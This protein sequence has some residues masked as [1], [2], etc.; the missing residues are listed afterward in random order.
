M[1]MNYEPLKLA[2][3]AVKTNEASVRAGLSKGDFRQSDVATARGIID[4]YS[5]VAPDYSSY[6]ALDYGY[7]VALRLEED[8]IRAFDDTLKRYANAVANVRGDDTKVLGTHFDEQ[9]LEWAK[10]ISGSLTPPML[11]QQAL[12][13][14]PASMTSTEAWFDAT[15]SSTFSSGDGDRFVWL[16]KSGDDRHA[17]DINNGTPTLATTNYVTLT[18][19]S[20]LNLP[21]PIGVRSMFFVTNKGVGTVANNSVVPLA[22]E[23]TSNASVNHVFLSNGT[24]VNISVDG[25]NGNTANVRINGLNGSGTNITIAGIP[26]Y[27]TR[28][29]E[30]VV[31]NHTDLEVYQSVAS[32]RVAAIYYYHLGDV[33]QAMF[34]NSLLQPEDIFRLEGYYHK[35]YNFS[36]PSDHPYLNTTPVDTLKVEAEDFADYYDVDAGNNGGAELWRGTDVDTTTN[37][38]VT[39][40]GWFAIG[41]WLEYNINVTTPGVYRIIAAISSGFSGSPTRTIRVD[42]GEQTANITTNVANGWGSYVEVAADAT[43]TLEPG[44]HKVR[45]TNTVSS[46]NFDYWLLKPT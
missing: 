2:I 14:T 3:Q 17:T 21:L 19:D 1:L 11:Q 25:S 37:A 6:T 34:F 22:G 18:G 46:S 44:N 45:F 38:G 13:W 32:M 33:G 5:D 10:A 35:I 36:L 31:V 39:T 7:G 12:A 30:A 42:C 28:P 41:E 26:S 16:D 27:T 9:Q 24:T 40:I 8:D 20:Y 4:G 43:F 15:D 29:V 23:D